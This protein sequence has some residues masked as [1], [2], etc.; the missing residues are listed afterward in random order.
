MGNLQCA[1]NDHPADQ[2]LT[3]A[4]FNGL[5]HCLSCF[6]CLHAASF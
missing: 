2:E 3:S 4:V 5:V 1:K 6:I